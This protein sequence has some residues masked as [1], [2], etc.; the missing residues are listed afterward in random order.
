MGAGSSLEGTSPQWRGLSLG[1]L[2]PPSPFQHLLFLAS[3]S[4]PPW[5]V[6]TDPDHRQRRQELQCHRLEGKCGH[7]A[8]DS[9]GGLRK[10]ASGPASLTDCVLV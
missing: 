3:G 1:P 9:V 2:P 8:G 6:G 5:H 7:L 10:A 4:Q